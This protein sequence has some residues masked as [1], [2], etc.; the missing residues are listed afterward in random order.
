L[1]EFIADSGNE[2]VA[3][4]DDVADFDFESLFC[5]TTTAAPRLARS[6]K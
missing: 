6:K 2:A 4:R 3:D 1:I 5:C